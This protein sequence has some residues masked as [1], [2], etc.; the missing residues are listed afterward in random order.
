M[1]S[2]SLKT[3]FVNDLVFSIIGLKIL[4]TKL[5]HHLF[6]SLNISMQGHIIITHKNNV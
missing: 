4:I 3:I 5:D 6:K 2:K 1:T